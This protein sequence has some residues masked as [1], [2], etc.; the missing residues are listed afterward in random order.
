MLQA[1][2]TQAAMAAALLLTSAACATKGHV[3]TELDALRASQAEALAAE[4]ETRRNADSEMETRVQ[5]RL[6]QL[7]QEMQSLRSDLGQLRNEFG[8]RISAMEDT[9]K[10]AM[11]VHFAFNDATVRE[12]DRPVIERLAAVIQRYYPNSAVTIEGFA[13]PAG[14]TRYNEQLS[15]RRAEAVRAALESFGLGGPN[16]NAVGYGETRL[17]VPNAWGDA[18]GAEMNRRVVFVVETRDSPMRVMTM[19]EGND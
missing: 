13:D 10:F 15:Q 4:A 5:Q 1:R 8:V 6:D 7:Q 11:P 16:V 12:A 9:L 17:V 14:S 2:S 18:P 19:D 3:R